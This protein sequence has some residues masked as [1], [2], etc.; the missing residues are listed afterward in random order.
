[1][2]L[3]AGVVQSLAYALTD[4]IWLTLGVHAGANSAAF[5]VSGLWHAGAVVSL[6]GQPSVPN[7]AAVAIMLAAF[8]VAFVLSQRY[9]ISP[10]R[11]SQR[12]G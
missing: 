7:W 4:N 10:L 3:L 11:F 12:A 2:L 9:R 1:M 5:S 8:S 6:T